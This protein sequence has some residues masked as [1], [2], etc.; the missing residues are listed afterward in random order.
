[1]KCSDPKTEEL[2][3][4]YELG[5]LSEEKRARFEEHLLSCSACFDEL[6]EAAPLA[7]RLRKGRAVHTRAIDRTGEGRV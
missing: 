5:L 3:G 2:T 4:S 7:E 6:Y 1:M